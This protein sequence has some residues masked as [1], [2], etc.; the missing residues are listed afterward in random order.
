MPRARL[1]PP[2]I[3]V[4]YVYSACVILETSDVSVLCDPWFSEGIYDGSWFHFPR[5]DDPLE[6][7]GDI[8]FVW[9]SHIHPDHYDPRF[10]RQYMDRFGEKTVLVAQRKYPYLELALRREGFTV[11]PMVE[12]MCVG[13]TTLESVAIR[14]EDRNE[15]DSALHVAYRDVS[16]KSHSVL[17]V[18]DIV[19]D[20]QVLSDLAGRFHRPDIL[21][22]GYTG[23]GP[24]PQT[25][26]DVSD[27]R[28]MVEAERKKHAFFERYRKNV[29]AFDAT[30]N[31]PFAGK[32]I[33]GGSRVHLNPFR[34]VADAVEVLPFDERAVVLC[35]L[36]GCVST[37]DM[38]PRGVRHERYADEDMT[39]RCI[40]IAGRQM[41]YELIDE[42]LLELVPFE[43][44]L[45]N[46]HTR[47]LAVSVVSED[48]FFVFDLPDGRRVV[49]NANPNSKDSFF[50]T[51]GADDLPE[52]RSEIRMDA[53][54][55]FG[56]LTGVFHWN[57]AE[58][59]SQ[60][61]VRRVPNV[62]K[63]EV[64]QFLNFLSV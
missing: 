44:L 15:I 41:T 56:L 17:N 23:A 24:Y 3:T 18:N 51:S 9:I 25:Y 38:I 54:Y 43:R 21:L 26:F 55:L 27:S 2:G 6:V 36:V 33:L 7:I 50:V 5:V 32:Y 34:G 11:K 19:F 35:D 63:R 16:G 60:Y 42:K 64:Q 52:P 49:M 14:P 30:M 12:D 62:F 57:T 10:L 45:R 39:A 22:L 40:E 48:H 59:G 47:A 28:L 13:S 8:D 1:V 61:D 58:V 4:T 31:I 46:A 29:A 20:E 37:S 53:R